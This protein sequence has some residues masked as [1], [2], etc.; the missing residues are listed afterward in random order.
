MLGINGRKFRI[1]P[2]CRLLHE[3]TTKNFD[4]KN[5]VGFGYCPYCHQLLIFVAT[6]FQLC[7]LMSI[8][9]KVFDEFFSVEFAY[10]H[11]LLYSTKKLDEEDFLK[12]DSFF[13]KSYSEYFPSKRIPE[14]KPIYF[15]NRVINYDYKFDT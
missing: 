3:F 10:K 6:P 5:Q 1:S 14:V 11:G 13:A 9:C 12:L 15:Q 7:G 4:W 2:C 8:S